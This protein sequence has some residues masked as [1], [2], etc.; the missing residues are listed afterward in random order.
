M[1][2]SAMDACGQGNRIKK[3]ASATVRRR[4]VAQAA[5]RL[6]PTPTAKR[7]IP[8]G[9]HPRKHGAAR[10]V[11]IHAEGR[12]SHCLSPRGKP[13][14][15]IATHL[16]MRLPCACGVVNW[17]SHAEHQGAMIS[18]ENTNP[19]RLATLNDEDRAAV[20]FAARHLYSA[21]AR[22]VWLFGS[23]A[24]GRKP[25]VHSDFDFAVEG[26]PP[27]K[28]FGCVGHLLQKLPRPVDIVE[29]ECASEFLAG[30][31]REEGVEL[32]P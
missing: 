12:M 20:Q 5:L 6:N 21:G 22:R 19:T 18:S 11:S 27:E 23:L 32:Q 15:G 8:K 10:A 3:R 26:L 29:M 7:Q 16:L 25:G 1:N 2:G 30:R 17:R 31:V 28:L 24:K 13:S 9:A 14:F 4:T